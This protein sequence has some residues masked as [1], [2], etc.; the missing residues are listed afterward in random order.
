[1]NALPD[2][3]DHDTRVLG[4]NQWC[5]LNNF[6]EATG[7][8]LMKTG[9]GPTVTQLSERRVGITIANNRAWQDARARTAATA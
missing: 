4:F 8:R 3:P 1:M 6:S 5:R 9:Q 7:R 2:L